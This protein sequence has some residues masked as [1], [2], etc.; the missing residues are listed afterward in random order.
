MNK[1]RA[2]VFL[3][4][5]LVCA[6]FLPRLLACSSDG[7]G[8]DGLAE[9][10]GGTV[11]VP[12]GSCSSPAQ[13]CPCSATGT[14]ATC[15][16]VDVTRDGFKQCSYGTLTCGAAGTWGA[17]EGAVRVQSLTTGGKRFTAQDLQLDASSCGD[18]DPCDPY[19][20]GFTDTPIG[21]SPLPTGLG[22]SDGG[23]TVVA[24][25]DAGMIPGTLQTTSN[26]ESACGMA[27]NLG[28]GSGCNT[29]P[30][31][32]CQQDFRCDQASNTCVWNAGEGYHDNSVTGPDLTV[33][34]PC[35]FG[36]TTTSFPV[37]NRGGTAVPSGGNI[38]IN[39]I[40]TD[41]DGGSDAGPPMGCDMI[42]PA[43]CSVPVPSDG[44]QPGACLNI[45]CP[46]TQ[47]GGYAVVNA[48]GRDTAEATGYCANNSAFAQS[49]DSDGGTSCASCTYC[50]TRVKGTVMDPGGNVGLRDM[51]V[52]ELA[53]T[54]SAP[55]ALPDNVGGIT[56][57]PCDTCDTLLPTSL[58]SVADNTSK[59]GQF[60]LDDVT[61]GPNQTIVVQ[62]GRWRHSFTGNIPACHTTDFDDPA[63]VPDTTALWMPSKHGTTSFGSYTERG[64]I[65]KIGFVVG[66][67]EQLECWM[68]KLGIDPSEMTPYT[69]SGDTQRIQMFQETQS[70]NGTPL[71]YAGSPGFLDPENHLWGGMHPALN[72]YSAILLSCN[73][74][75]IDN[76]PTATLSAYADSG[77]RIF[78][79]HYWGETFIANSS[80]WGGSGVYTWND[81][82]HFNGTAASPAT[83]KIETA[84]TAQQHMYDWLNQW[85]GGVSSS[86]PR[87]NAVTAGSAS[88]NWIRGESHNNFSG[89]HSDGDYA[90]SFSFETPVGSSTTCG[91]VLFNGMHASA[92]RKKEQCHLGCFF[93][94]PPYC[95]LGPPGCTNDDP[96]VFPDDCDLG[97]GLTSEEKALEYQLFQVTA[98]ALGGAPPP[99]PP[100]PP[101]ALASAVF[102]RDF[103][104]TC[105]P[106][107][108][109]VWQAFNWDADIPDG[110][111]IQYFAATSTTSAGLPPVVTAAPA[112]VPIGQATMSVAA[113]FWGSDED[114]VD[115]HLQN[116][117]PG[118][119]QTSESYLRIYM[120]FEPTGT[121]SPTLYD[122]QQLYDCIPDQ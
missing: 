56:P 77:G 70:G 108:K 92:T 60:V 13:G 59:K 87:N 102:T 98:C 74:S 32:S 58:Y 37:C 44:L 1:R 96:L 14:T 36:G 85:A 10:D 112:T 83:G 39:F 49:A 69:G 72:D 73:G 25:S 106:G 57:P 66:A 116:E 55:P 31:S 113:P 24:T 80:E 20:T 122:W 45:P 90:L 7:D 105:D 97:P 121:T 118:P 119:P 104:A 26:G 50:E 3:P 18:A 78:M 68:L 19:C 8:E 9:P 28:G 30:I 41:P 89:S 29:N 21:I 53:G 63:D 35:A 64:D 27:A 88:T 52:Y 82:S 76:E 79:D 46:I 16:Q 95:G 65:P 54:A 12:T 42:G 4:L 2:A 81:E 94:F 111:R 75:Y 38:G 100:P 91:R 110:T 103:Y 17:C 67:L 107:Y 101:P 11:R 84:T 6:I 114:T 62:S 99:A 22:L 61:P 120:V 5:F 48:G 23:L 43:T 117:P 15:G 40:S 109:L 93:G 71:D 86:Q 47:T 34:T 33:G 115:W 51:T